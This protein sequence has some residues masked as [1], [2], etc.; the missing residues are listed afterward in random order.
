MPLKESGIGRGIDVGSARRARRQS[1]DVQALLLGQAPTP[2]GCP[3]ETLSA[4]SIRVPGSR[5]DRPIGRVIV[6]DDR[7]TGL[8]P[9]KALLQELIIG[10]RRARTAKVRHARPSLPLEDPGQHAAE[11]ESALA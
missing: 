7:P 9:P 5:D 1:L 3:T 6:V 10:Q 11:M 8:R 4:R 2:E